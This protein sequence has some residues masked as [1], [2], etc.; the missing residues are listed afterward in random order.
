MAS[1]DAPG[2][3]RAGGPMV[4]PGGAPGAHPGGAQEAE[5]PV[6][7]WADPALVAA[8]CECG[9][10]VAGG[11]ARARAHQA[12]A[13]ARC[14]WTVAVARGDKPGMVAR[15]MIR[16]DAEAAASVGIDQP[17]RA[18]ARQEQAVAALV[19]PWCGRAPPFP[20]RWLRLDLDRPG[21]LHLRT[22]GQY[23]L[24]LWLVVAPES[25]VAL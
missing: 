19:L 25:A 15:V 17:D 22:R 23:R 13:V 8:L 21:G 7:G 20:G 10:A 24:A 3:T 12:L 18:I 14:A 2:L 1:E 16:V 4:G 6:T 9:H 11:Q 5:D